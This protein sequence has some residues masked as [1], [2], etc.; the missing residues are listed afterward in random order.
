MRGCLVAGLGLR[1]RDGRLDP[2]ELS[3]ELASRL[4]RVGSGEMGLPT[5]VRRSLERSSGACDHLVPHGGEVGEGFG[6][7]LDV[8]D[9]DI[10]GDQADERAGGGHAV[11][12]V[13]EPVATVQRCGLD[14]QAVVGFGDLAAEP[15]DLGGQRLQPVGFMPA[16]VRNPESTDVPSARAARAAMVGV[17]SPMSCRSILMGTVGPG[18]PPSADR[19]KALLHNPC[20]AAR[21]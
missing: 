16:Q 12:G 1:R 6:G 13:R 11:I 7:G 14:A 21:R 3:G 10:V 9:V 8:V 19:R 4:R 2:E 20:R 15:V 18:R 5:A 17:S